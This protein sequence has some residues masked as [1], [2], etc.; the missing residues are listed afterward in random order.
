MAA[1]T[2]ECPTPSLNV[3]QNIDESALFVA[4]DGAKLFFVSSLKR[5]I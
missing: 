4:N 1:C 3:A 2:L 5:S